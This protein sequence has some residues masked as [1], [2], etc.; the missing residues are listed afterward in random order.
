MSGQKRSD[1]RISRLKSG[2]KQGRI[3]SIIADPHFVNPETYD[4]HFKNLSIAKKIKFIPFDYSRAGVYGSPEWRKLAEF[5]PDLA[6]EFDNVVL[7]RESI[8]Q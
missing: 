6:K 5:D 4:F 7:Q 8:R 3:Y 1:L 2:R